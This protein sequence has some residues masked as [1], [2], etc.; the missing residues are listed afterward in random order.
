[1]NTEVCTWVEDTG[2]KLTIKFCLDVDVQAGVSRPQETEKAPL[3]SCTK[4]FHNH[5]HGGLGARQCPVLLLQGW[6]RTVSPV[7]TLITINTSAGPVAVTNSSA[8][9]VFYP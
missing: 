7:K 9:L 1:M 5:T 2:W 8:S 3:M 6:S 4:F